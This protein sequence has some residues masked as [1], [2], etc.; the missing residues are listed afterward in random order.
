MKQ[1]LEAVLF[2][3]DG[4]IFDT[5]II[6]RHCWKLAGQSFEYEVNDDFFKRCTATTG[7]KT[8][9]LLSELY[10]SHCPAESFYQHKKELFQ[11]YI[12]S[13][14]TQTKAGF[15]ELFQWLQSQPVK[16]GLVTSSRLTSVKHHFADRDEFESFE[17]VITAEQV[18]QGK[19]DPEPYLMACKKL[20]VTPSEAVVFEDSNNGARSAF[21]AGCHAIMVPDYLPPEDDVQKHAFAILNSLKDARALLSEQFQMN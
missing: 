16:I 2:D 6:H 9:A 5:E 17:T 4:L 15:T 10:G 11:D 1:K 14:P 20:G 19:P 21:N 7:E 13:H 8:L 12:N 18:T 3:M